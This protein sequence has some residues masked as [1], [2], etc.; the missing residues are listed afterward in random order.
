MQFSGHEVRRRYDRESTTK[1]EAEIDKIERGDNDEG[2]REMN[3]REGV[4]RQREEREI[5][6]QS[7]GERRL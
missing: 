6:K 5:G 7:M 2:E 3:Y 1:G 4:G